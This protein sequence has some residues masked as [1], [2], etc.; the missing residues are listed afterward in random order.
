MDIILCCHKESEL[1]IHVRAYVI[2]GQL[3]IEGQD[4]G[5]I[6][7]ENYGDLDYEYFYSLSKTDTKKLHELLKNDSNSNKGLLELM[8]VYFSG[9]YGCAKFRDYCEKNS[10]KYEFFSYC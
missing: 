1:E 10:L 7:E 9:V 2:D 8:S 6:V 3:K 4:L 5:S